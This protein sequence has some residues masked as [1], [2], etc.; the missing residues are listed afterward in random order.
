MAVVTKKSDLY[1]DPHSLDVSVEPL[2]AKGRTMYATGTITNEATDNTASKYLLGE[3]PSDCLLHE[4]TFFDVENDGFAQIQ[5]GT[6]DDAAALINQTK[7][8]ET[9]I[10]PI[11]IGDAWH[12]KELWQVL[13]LAS[14]PGGTI[15][16]YKHAAADAAAA[17]SMLFRIVTI[18]R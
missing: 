7:I 4:D 12:G 3:F 16:I 8:T 5:I 1:R 6:L 11:A 13:G 10:Q 9:I 14:D 17:G 18:W 2:K 15:R